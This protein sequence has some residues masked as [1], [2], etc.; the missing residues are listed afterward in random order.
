MT[1]EGNLRYRGPRREG[2]GLID[3][4]VLDLSDLKFIEDELRSI[5]ALEVTSDEYSGRAKSVEDFVVEG[6]KSLDSVR[7]SATP[8]QKF[9]SL[10]VSVNRLYASVY[11][12]MEDDRAVEG[13]RR[14]LED[15]LRTRVRRFYRFA[16][17]VGTALGLLG[18]ALF[19]VAGTLVREGD[20]RPSG[21]TYWLLGV[22]AV[23]ILLGGGAVLYAS[24]AKG[25]I[26]LVRREDRPGWIRRNRDVLT[27][28]VVSNVIALAVGVF[29]GSLF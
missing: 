9:H 16:S 25:A 4:V 29:V 23:A 21:A 14:V 2:I 13:V 26:W 7:F 15:F 28:Q 19:T 22:G 20:Q 11:S 17:G 5:G 6:V 27:V 3:R 24:T 12:S 1:S 18:F 10:S 8:H